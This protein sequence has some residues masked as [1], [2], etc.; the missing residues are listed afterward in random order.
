MINVGQYTIVPWILWDVFS[1]IVPTDCPMDGDMNR[2]N[3]RSLLRLG[4][5]IRLGQ[6]GKKKNGTTMMWKIHWETA[7]FK[8][9]KALKGVGVKNF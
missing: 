4:H 2:Q 7:V 9:L 3:L 8:P 6:T 5:E 1:H